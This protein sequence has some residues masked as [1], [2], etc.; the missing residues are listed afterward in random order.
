MMTRLLR[1]WIGAAVATFLLT[2]GS[3]MSAASSLRAQDA[4]SLSGAAMTST[5]QAMP[6]V[7]VQLRELE[8]ARVVATTTTTAMGSFTFAGIS[9]GQ[10]VVEIVSA[11]GQIIGT[12]AAVAVTAGKPVTGLSVVESRDH[13]TGAGAASGSSHGR[14][15]AIIAAAAGAAAIV[16]AVSVTGTASA[17]R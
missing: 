1:V 15:V 2:A 5:G 9:A 13:A 14:T 10:Y 16:T 8:T 17:S 4:G 7:A 12:S 11:A 6:N 3:A